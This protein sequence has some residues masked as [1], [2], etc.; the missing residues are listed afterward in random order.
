MIIVRLHSSFAFVVAC[1]ARTLIR[2]SCRLLRRATTAKT[3]RLYNYYY[4]VYSQTGIRAQMQDVTHVD[5]V[6]EDRTLF[7]V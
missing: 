1:T 3:W 7:L 5:I 6:A 2:L 4:D